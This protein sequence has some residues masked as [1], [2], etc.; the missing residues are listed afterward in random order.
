MPEDCDVTDAADQRSAETWRLEPAIAASRRLERAAQWWQD[1]AKDGPVSADRAKTELPSD[2]RPTV[3]LAEVL[4][5]GLDF[6][7]VLAGDRVVR[8]SKSPLVGELASSR[9]GPAEESVVVSDL[10]LT[11]RDRQPVAG[12]VGYVGPNASIVGAVHLM[13]PLAGPDGE[14]VE[15][16]I[17]IDYLETPK[18]EMKS[19]YRRAAGATGAWLATA[20]LLGALVAASLWLYGL[21]TIRESER[22]AIQSDHLTGTLAA[23][24]DSIEGVVENIALLAGEGAPMTPERFARLAETLL[25]DHPA[26]SALRAVALAPKIL[27]KERP[28]FAQWMATATGTAIPPWPESDEPLGFPLLFIWPDPFTNWLLGHDFWT[29]PARRAAA[30]R[31]L[32]T[33]RVKVAEPMIVPDEEN[34]GNPPEVIS[35]LVKAIDGPVALGLADDVVRV[36]NAIIAFGLTLDALLESQLVGTAEGINMV[37]F[38]GGAVGESG[39]QVITDAS[40]ESILLA[41][42]PDH[43]TSNMLMGDG[44]L[45]V[46]EFAGRRIGLWIEP[47]T[48][49]QRQL[50][51]IVSGALLGIGLL[52]SG[53]LAL[54]LRRISATRARI[55][56]LARQRSE[57]IVELSRELRVKAHH[58]RMAD[59]ARS[60]LLSTLS[61]ELRTP[62]NGIMGFTELL[63][64]RF[65]RL[66]ESDRRRYLDTVAQS[67]DHMRQ[68]IGRLLEVSQTVPSADSIVP[69]PVALETLSTWI[70]SMSEPVARRYGVRVRLDLDGPDIDGLAVRADPLALRQAI[71]NFVDNGLKFTA[72]GG[73]VTVMAQRNQRGLL[74]TVADT[75]IG[76]SAARVAALEEPMAEG[77]SEPVNGS[78]GLGLGL[79][80]SRGLLALMGFSTSIETTLGEGT[81]VI[82]QIPRAAL[83]EPQATPKVANA[84]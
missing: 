30:M 26:E 81:R 65:D 53:L 82:V 66:S 78:K 50:P 49:L 80:L 48:L 84:R 47:E 60:R 77:G 29:H 73:C 37:V 13:L 27:P 70:A 10:Q 17:V 52:L 16:L 51:E 69:E 35:V 68:V 18:S 22:L 3:V 44:K 19:A 24:L 83:I 64:M 46:I 12:S 36:D 74:L 23:T 55:E 38:D 4:K 72:S 41:A 6:R 76:M 62:L 79:S 57:Q 21:L 1:L 40:A 15:I 34:L 20:T 75:G 43:V 28:K 31:S 5:D 45:S 11:H 56:G 2:L 7:V 61:H 42:A 71:L 54:Y 58:A 67:G 8:H 63:Q 14:I 32:D 39:P 33:G 9:F 59:T 25:E